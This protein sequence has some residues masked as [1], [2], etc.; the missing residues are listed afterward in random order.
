MTEH[1]IGAYR[2]ERIPLLYINF[3]V[4]SPYKCKPVKLRRMFV[5]SL[6][7]D[8]RSISKNMHFFIMAELL[9]DYL[10]LLSPS[11]HGTL[12]NTK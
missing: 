7:Y 1:N 9:P 11:A 10:Y 3:S 5:Q 12:A 6:N 4:V 8:L 2:L